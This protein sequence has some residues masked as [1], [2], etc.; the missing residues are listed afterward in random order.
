MLVVATAELGTLNHT[1]LT[2]EGLATRRLSCAGMVIGS[3]PEHPDA[4]QNSNREALARLAP[5]RAVLPAGAGA[6]PA[7]Q[8]AALS[9]AAF[10]HGWVTALVS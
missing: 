8:F 6:L 4:V 2:L 7:A 5:L 10:D 3:W 9:A 1:A